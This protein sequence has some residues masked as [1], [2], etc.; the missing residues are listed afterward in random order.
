MAKPPGAKRSEILGASVTSLKSQSLTKW[1]IDGCARKA[2]CAKGLVIH[3]FASRANLLNESAGVLLSARVAGWRAAL[4]GEGIG[5]LDLLW[6]QLVEEAGDG[7][8]RALIELRAA[9]VAGAALGPADAAR[10]TDAL[11]RALEAPAA[12]LPT[13]LA[14][15]PILE[16]YL[17]ALQSDAGAARVRDAFFRYWL[18]FVE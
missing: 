16:G 9:G 1:S 8:G 7:S 17:L 14:F 3:Y 12:Q 13:P 11:A 2:H 15:E 4:S 6:D 5:A 10:L 18:S